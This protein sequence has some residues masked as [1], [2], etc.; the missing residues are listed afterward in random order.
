MIV[1]NTR[2]INTLKQNVSDLEEKRNKDREDI[3][4]NTTKLINLEKDVC[5]LK[6]REP[7]AS[8]NDDFLDKIDL[9]ESKKPRPL[10]V[11]FRNPQIK[12]SILKAA[13]K[14]AKT[15]YKKISLA[16]DLTPLQL[17]KKK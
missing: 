10:T 4:T 5:E 13:W 14:L 15:E 3:D 1:N 12:D 17:Q 16:P 6:E 8:S 11:G 9:S 2:E 7:N